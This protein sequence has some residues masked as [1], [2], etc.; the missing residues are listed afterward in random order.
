MTLKKKEMTLD[1]KQIW[2][3]FLFKFKMSHKA[4]ETTHNINN[5]FGLETADKCWVRWWVRKFCLGDESLE[6]EECS[7]QPLVV[8]SDQ[9]RAIIEAYPVTTTEEIAQEH[10]I[11]HS[12]VVWHL[13]RIGKVK[14]L[15]KQCLMSW[16]QIKKLVL[17][18]YRLLLYATVTNYF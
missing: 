13:K 10:N 18:C 5:A 9:L 15:S 16:P 8:D 11:N 1:K 6:D 14:K 12:V 17:M 4:V 3:I 7:G 2:T